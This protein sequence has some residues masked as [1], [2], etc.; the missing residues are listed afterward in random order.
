MSDKDI[1]DEILERATSIH[2]KDFFD[3][4]VLD[5]DGTYTASRAVYRG[6][7]NCER[8]D[9]FKS[10]EEAYAWIMEGKE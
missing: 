9:G 10:L 3:S 6:M 8:K 1:R 4:I 5:D 7:Q 2:F